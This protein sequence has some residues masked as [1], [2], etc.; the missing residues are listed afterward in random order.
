MIDLQRLIDLCD[1][2]KC[3]YL[4][5]Q[6]LSN[7]T[8]FRIGG[9]CPIVVKP[10]T[11]AQIQSLTAFCNENNYDYYYFGKGSNLLVNDNGVD[12]VVIVLG[13]NFSD[14]SLKNDSTIIASAGVS[15]AKICKFALEKSLTGLEFAFGI[16]G[17]LGGAVFMN[18]GAYGGEIKDIFVA[19]DTVDKNGDI[20]RFSKEQADLSYRHSVFMQKEMCIVSV[21]LK[22]EKGDKAEIKAKMDELLGRR[23]DKQPLDY[24]S[25][26]S[27]FKR[28]VGNYAAALIDECG[29]KGL[30]VGGAQVSEKHSGF[31]I[32]KDN[33][34]CEDVLE[35]ISKVKETVYEKTQY[36]LECEV[37]II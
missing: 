14:I 36:K 31:V 30:T 7:Y 28:P 12:A 11:V 27:T 18:A 26:G 4:L 33:A 17:T 34:T 15:L 6:K 29:L 2:I 22:L 37:K 5:N 23:K 20:H 3:E 16:P 19:C 32:N 8:T 9:E 13:D 10:S 1:E 24:P 35:L 21:E 25:A